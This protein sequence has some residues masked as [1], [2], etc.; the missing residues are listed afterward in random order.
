MLQNI[1]FFYSMYC[2]KGKV[3]FA[4]LGFGHFYHASLRTNSSEMAGKTK[5][6]MQLF[7][8]TQTQVLN[9]KLQWK[10]RRGICPVGRFT[11]LPLLKMRVQSMR[12]R[13]LRDDGELA[14]PRRGEAKRIGELHPFKIYSYFFFSLLV[15]SIS[16]ILGVVRIDSKFVANFSL[17]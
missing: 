5:K 16:I 15:E 10:L 2:G 12:W 3:L 11:E 9:G 6:E 8:Q 4:Y 1:I 13:A 14:S 17:V 7:L